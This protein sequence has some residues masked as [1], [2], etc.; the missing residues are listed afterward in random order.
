M[1]QRLRVLGAPANDLGQFTAFHGSIQLPVTPVSGHQTHSSG[2]CMHYHPSV[3][4][5]YM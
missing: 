1:V 3:M 4:H 2:L 5:T